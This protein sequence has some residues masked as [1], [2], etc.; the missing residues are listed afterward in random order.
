MVSLTVSAAASHR[1]LLI[2]L[3]LA[4][5]A[6]VFAAFWLFEVPGLGVG[7]F[8]Y[9][10][11]ALLALAAGMWAGIGGGIVAAGLYVLAIFA[12]PRVPTRDALTSA[13]VIR[14]I[15]YCSVGALIGWFAGKYREHVARLRELADRDFLTGLLNAR[16]FD[17]ALARRCG[18]DSPFVLLLG[19]IDNLK[20]L[21]DTHGHVEGN[22]ALRHVSETFAAAIAPDD[23]LA[24][25]GGDEFAVLM[26]GSVEEAHAVCTLLKRRLAREGLDLSFGWS[27]RPDDG[28][29]P[30]E[31]FRKAD[32]RLYAAKLLSRNRRAVM[33]LAGATQQS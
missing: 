27:A 29:G 5:Y 30:V 11:V 12:T 33:A 1:R 17:E 10:P 2:S 15:T 13:T 7:H 14:V 19:D 23:D 9:L 16:V 8:F 4:L 3:A 20:E 31:L 28:L 22:R 6:A 18:S 24:R 32:D 25:V 21:N 26:T